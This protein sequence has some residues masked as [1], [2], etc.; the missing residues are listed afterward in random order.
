VEPTKV[1]VINSLSRIIG[2]ATIFVILAM[3]VLTVSDVTMR[4]LFSRPITGTTEITEYMMICILLA[5]AWGAVQEKH[6]TVSAVMDRMPKKVQ[7]ITDIITFLISL[8]VFALVTWQSYVAALFALEFNVSS[9]LLGLPDAPFY[10][11]LMAGF[12]ILCL[13]IIPVLVKRIKQAG[14]NE[15]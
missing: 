4:Y 11:V 14:K 7:A 2:H 9:A 15:L 10:I 6:I 8:G 5:M 12:G 1:K 13:S 3:M